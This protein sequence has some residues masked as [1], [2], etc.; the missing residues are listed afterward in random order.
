MTSSGKEVEFD[1]LGL[2][3]KAAPEDSDGSVSIV[4]IRDIVDHI[5]NEALKIRSNSPQIDNGKVAILLALEFA[6]T[7]L[8]LERELKGTVNSL[9]QEAKTALELLEDINPTTF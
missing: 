8:T 6:K 3:I 2:R 1:V 7:K 9:Y 5:N 4:S